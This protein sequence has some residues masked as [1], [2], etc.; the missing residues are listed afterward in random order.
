MTYQASVGAGNY[1]GDSSALTSLSFE[2]LHNNGFIDEVLG[3]GTKSGYHFI[4]AQVPA[5][6][7]RPPQFTGYAYPVT[8][9]GANQTGTQVYSIL[10]DGVVYQG[11]Y[12]DIVTTT[13]GGTLITTT[14]GTPVGR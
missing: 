5:S 9:S 14:G 10:T 11:N 6:N 3:S 7:G 4:G 13:N 1:A 2:E 12:G 8:P